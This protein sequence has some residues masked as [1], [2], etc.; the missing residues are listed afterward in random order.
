MYELRSGAKAIMSQRYQ[1]Y[2]CAP[3]HQICITYG[4]TRVAVL[5]EPFCTLDDGSLSE[6]AM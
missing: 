4:P 5:S 1:S 3:R 6:A 2:V